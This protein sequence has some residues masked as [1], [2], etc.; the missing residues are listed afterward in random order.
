MFFALWPDAATTANLVRATRGA[1]QHS[2][3]RPC[4]K[5]QLHVTVAFLGGLTQMQLEQALSTPPIAVGPFELSLDRLGFWRR[6]Q[7]LWIAPRTVPSP[8]AELERRLW[9][10]LIERGFEREPQIYRPHLT[11]ARRARPVEASV[12]AVRWRVDDLTLVE[13]TP[14]TRGAHY[15]VLHRWPL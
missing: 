13:S 8:L 15:E 12:T 7:V 3:G 4:A 11:L 5:D 9:L 10:A 14:T 1:V 6:S 2:G